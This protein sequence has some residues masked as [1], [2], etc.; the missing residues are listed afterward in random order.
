MDDPFLAAYLVYDKQR[1]TA[2]NRYGRRTTGRPEPSR[3][4]WYRTLLRSAG[5]HSMA[6]AAAAS[7]GLRLTGAGE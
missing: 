2:R 4:S 5:R 7:E 6:R 3:R 1:A